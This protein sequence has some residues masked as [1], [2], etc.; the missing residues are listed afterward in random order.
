MTYLQSYN[1]ISLIKYSDKLVSHTGL[2][3]DLVGGNT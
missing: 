3:K 1:T 2:W